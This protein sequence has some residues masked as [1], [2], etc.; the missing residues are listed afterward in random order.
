MWRRTASLLRRLQVPRACRKSPASWGTRTDLYSVNIVSATNTTAESF[1]LRF[2][3]EERVCAWDD[4]RVRPLLGPT[5]VH[6]LR[7]IPQYRFTPDLAGTWGLS[8]H[9]KDAEDSFDTSEGRW[10]LRRV[11][12]GGGDKDAGVKYYPLVMYGG[13]KEIV[14]LNHKS[15]ISAQVRLYTCTPENKTLRWR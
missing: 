1:I 5:I 6:C 15:G 11:A 2:E 13:V 10:D 4:N 7:E 3:G 14:V 9:E 8:G 12:L